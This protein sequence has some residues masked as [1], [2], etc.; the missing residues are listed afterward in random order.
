MSNII[1]LLLAASGGGCIGYAFA[2][3]MAIAKIADLE[4][5]IVELRRELDETSFF[6]RFPIGPRHD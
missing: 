6:T 2:A 3:I 5:T 1:A 4:R